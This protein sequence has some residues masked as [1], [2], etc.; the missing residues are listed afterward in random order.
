M[1]KSQEIEEFI[2]RWLGKYYLSVTSNTLGLHCTTLY[3][4][5]FSFFESIAKINF[6]IN[7]TTFNWCCMTCNV[8]LRR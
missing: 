8:L 5:V 1:I 2:V 4:L 7:R 6:Q 3:A